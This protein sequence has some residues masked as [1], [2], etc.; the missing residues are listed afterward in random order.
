[1][2]TFDGIM[3]VPTTLS[4]RPNIR[5]MCVSLDWGRSTTLT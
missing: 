2:A 1:M 4:G 5:G 3:C